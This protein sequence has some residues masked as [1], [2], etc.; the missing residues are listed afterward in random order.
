MNINKTEK[1]IRPCDHFYLL[2]FIDH[3]I[4]QEEKNGMQV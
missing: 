3:Q 1:P 4:N 2:D